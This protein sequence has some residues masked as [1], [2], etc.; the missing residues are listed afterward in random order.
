MSR[1]DDVSQLYSIASKLLK[2]EKYLFGTNLILA[3]FA[4]LINNSTTKNI[5]YIIQIIAIV[6]FVIINIYD[7]NIVWYKAEKTRRKTAIENSFNI[8]ITEF[9]TDGYYNNDIPPSIRKYITNIFE[10]IFFS[11][12]I[13]DKSILIECMK[14][15]LGIIIFIL[16]CLSKFDY[17]VILIIAQ[18]IFSGLLLSDFISFAFFKVRVDI[19]YD[20]FY[21]ELITNGLISCH[22][23]SSLLADVVEYEAIKA[24]H[25][26]RLSSKLFHKMNQKFGGDWADLEKKIRLNMQRDTNSKKSS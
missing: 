23:E 7:I 21:C 17:A 16:A 9:K 26:V 24:H 13:A 18:S 8:D 6:V 4:E 3:I 5:L 25:R 14:A 11:K 19:L 2:I 20:K 15:L 10:S 1:R 12:S 22:Q